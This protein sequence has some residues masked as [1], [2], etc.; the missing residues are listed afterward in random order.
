MRQWPVVTLTLNPAIDNSGEVERLV[1]AH[2]L[3]CQ[4]TRREPGGG[5]VNVARVLSRLG[6]P[7]L[8]VFPAGGVMGALYQHLITA[9]R[10]PH[11]AVAAAGETR[12]NLTVQDRTTGQQYRFVFPGPALSPSEIE[13][14]C[15]TALRAAGPS[16]YLVASGSLPPGASPDIYA[17][18]ARRGAA[19]GMRFVLDTSGEGLRHAL[20]EPLYLAK[21]SEHELEEA[22]GEAVTDRARCLAA[23]R[24]LIGKGPQLIAI[25]RGEKGGM[26]VAKDF[27]LEAN[28]PP[29]VPTSTVGAGDSFLAALLW[30]LVRGSAPA[31]A[32]QSAVA[33]G[34]AALLELGTEL[35]H[36]ATLEKL[37]ASVRVEDIADLKAPNAPAHRG[38]PSRRSPMNNF[39]KTD[40]GYFH[41]TNDGWTRHDFLPFPSNRIETWH[42][43][44]DWPAEDA[45]ERV[46][47]T[48][49]WS[50]P[51]ADHG[52]LEALHARYGEPLPPTRERNVTL[53]CNI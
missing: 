7:A 8:A 49:I 32:L 41:L 39:P 4:S 3:R 25:S 15:D 19:A 16:A 30:E 38:E 28:A 6:L 47:L 2:K 40:H 18:L 46:C 29:I 12:E 20:R 11:V 22:T 51:G 33:A 34:S 5:G 37:R 42:Y 1:P 53:E 27:A 48:K 43:E 21:L 9:Q 10:V 13:S 35:C 52:T 36:P 17:R 44:M 14:C 31:R 50:L 45:K 23:A 24:T 26:L